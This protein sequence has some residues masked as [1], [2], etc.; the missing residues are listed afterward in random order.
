MWGIDT[1][2]VL[3]SEFVW[4]FSGLRMLMMGIFV[5]ELPD[6][7]HDSLMYMEF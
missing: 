5:G 3:G 7:E 6:V 2:I 1:W 4:P